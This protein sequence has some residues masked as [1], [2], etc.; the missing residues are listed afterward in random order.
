MKH[1]HVALAV[2]RG[3]ELQ[4]VREARVLRPRS[5]RQ[6]AQRPDQLDVGP[7]SGAR[8]VSRAGSRQASFTGR[9]GRSSQ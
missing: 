5:F 6:N 3:S 8:S 9:T 7:H 1:V 2:G 4:E